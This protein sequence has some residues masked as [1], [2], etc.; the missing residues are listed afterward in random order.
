[1]DPRFWESRNPLSG[2]SV[3]F[4]LDPITSSR[5][6]QKTA[7][8]IGAA[9][10]LSSFD[11]EDPGMSGECGVEVCALE[12]RT[13]LSGG[14]PYRVVAKA[15]EA[16]MTGRPFLISGSDLETVSRLEGVVAR[17]SSRI[18]HRIEQLDAAIAQQPAATLG[19]MVGIVTGAI[20]LIKSFL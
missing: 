14:I 17:G 8:L 18:G 1:M 19:N 15:E 10:E 7:Y 2:K 16:A 5:L 3:D 12:A 13:I 11:E 20:G 6:A 4:N 9:K